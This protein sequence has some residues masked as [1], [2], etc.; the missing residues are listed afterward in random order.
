MKVASIITAFTTILAAS[1]FADAFSA[2]ALSSP[3]R[4][5]SVQKQ[6]FVDEMG[7]SRIFRGTNVVYK[8][9]P[10]AP[11]ITD[12]APPR[13]SFNK[14]DIEILAT[15]GVTAIRLGVMWPGV[16]P[17]RGQYDQNYLNTMKQIVQ[18]CQDAGIYVLLDMHQDNLSEKFCG[19]GV[20]LW[21]AQPTSGW[22]NV[23]AFPVPVEKSGYKSRDSRGV[24]SQ[25]DCNK[26]F[27]ADYQFAYEVA[28]AYQRI[29]DNHDGLR[30]SWVN[31]WKVVAQTFKGFNNILGY[32][33]IYTNPTLL[34]PGVADKKNLQGFYD[35]GAQGIRSVDPDAIIFYE[36]VTWDNFVVGFSNVPGG[37]AYKSKSV[38][39]FHHYDPKPN[40]FN[41][42]V[43]LLER[44]IDMER[45]GS[46]GMLTEFEMGWQNGG[47]VEA[48]RAKSKALEKHFFSYTGWEYTDY[49]PITGTNNGIRDPD[50]GLIRPDMA[51]VYSRTYASAIPGTPISQLFDDATGT[52]TLT[53]SAGTYSPTANPS[54]TLVGDLSATAV[55][56]RTGEQHYPRGLVVRVNVGGREDVR[57]QAAKGEKIGGGG[58]VMAV[59]IDNGFVYVMAKDGVNAATLG[60]KT[61]EVVVSRL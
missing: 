52:Y 12:D 39:S 22:F 40:L 29:Y 60:G 1:G 42:N 59:V 23:L 51:N 55:E 16:E 30:D 5:K 4:I 50:T 21:A 48:I 53:Y 7:R 36:S 2:P 37:D 17:V 35:A 25:D 9:P 27:W 6:L 57:V 38:L 41:L 10:Y 61:V 33:H 49:I 24:P 20:P 47:N 46:G 34:V 15:N 11:Q 54:A 43:T 13:Y 28:V 31:Y 32:D 45:L 26:H 58:G 8:A 3:K 56:I 14:R 18:W 19:E 44:F